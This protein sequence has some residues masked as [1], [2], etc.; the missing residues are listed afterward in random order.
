M[1][2]RQGEYNLAA[3][4][5][6][7]D[8]KVLDSILGTCMLRVAEGIRKSEVMLI[9]KILINEYY[10]LRVPIGGQEKAPCGADC[11]NCE[12]LKS[13]ECIGCP[14][15]KYYKGW[16]SLKSMGSSNSTK[17]LKKRSTLSHSY[18]AKPNHLSSNTQSMSNSV[19]LSTSLYAPG[20]SSEITL[21]VVALTY[22]HRLVKS[23]PREHL[24][25][26]IGE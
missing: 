20:A 24:T 13:N 1:Y 14:S 21:I 26:A 12:K 4:I 7:E 8:N 25:K 15:V 18:E 16:F 10:N 5:Y 2:K 22:S 3:L 11:Y 6:A 23:R 9:P 17:K 19:I